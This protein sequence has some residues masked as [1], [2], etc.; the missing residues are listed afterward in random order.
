MRHRMVD[1]ISAVFN[2]GDG[3]LVQLALFIL[4]DGELQPIYRAQLDIC[5]LSSLPLQLICREYVDLI[6]KILSQR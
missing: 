6:D 3:E 2:P 4:G 1:N 5:H